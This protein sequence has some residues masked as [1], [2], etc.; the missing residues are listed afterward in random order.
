MGKRLRGKH[1]ILIFV[2]ILILITL[3]AIITSCR[4]SRHFISDQAYRQLVHQ[5]FEKRMAVAAG[6]K[7]ALFDVFNEPLSLEEKE[8]LEFLYAFMPLSDLANLDGQYL[9][10]QVRSA[11][12]ARDF[13]SWGKSIPAD[14]FR[15]FVLPYR[16]NNENPDEARQVFF[17]ELKE[18]IKNLDMYQAALEV[19]HWCH[20]KVTYQ[21]TDERTSAPLATVKTA[22][23]RCGE[24]STFTVAALRAVSLP[25]RQVYTPRWAHT[26]DNHAWVEVWVHG[27]WYYLGA[28]EPEPEL[29]RGWFSGPATRAMLVHTTVYGQYQ[30]PEEV[31]GSSELFT[32]LNLLAFYAPTAKLKVQVQ[33]TEGQPVSGANVDFCL[34]N[35]AEFFPLV[36][37]LT[38]D[39][40]E[41]SLTTGF[42]DLII[43]AEKDGRVAWSQVSG[44]QTKPAV[45]VL[46]GDQLTGQEADLDIIPPAARNIPP[47]DPAKVEENNR[48]LQQ[49]DAIRQAYEASFITEDKARQWAEEKGFP[50][51]MTW[52]Y[53]QKSRGNWPEIIR[54]LEGLKPEEKDFGLTLLGAITEKDLRDTPAEVLLHHLRFRPEKMAGLDNETYVRYVVSPRIGRELLTSWRSAV[55]QKFSQNQWEEFRANP[56]LIDSWIENNIQPDDSNYYNVPLF[57]DRL[58]ELGRADD[59]SKKVLLVALART[60]GC[61]ARINQVSGQPAFL[62]G[63]KWVEIK[64][65][66]PAATEKANLELFYQTVA[67]INKPIYFTHFTLGRFDG[68]RY[69]TLNFEGDPALAS[70]PAE[71][72][73][74]AGQYRLITGNRQADGSVLSHLIHFQ[75]QPGEKK[76]V[77]L[78]LREK[79]TPPLVVGKLMAN[80]QIIKAEDQSLTD[81]GSLVGQNNFIL[82]LIAPDQEP[83][84]HLMGELQAFSSSFSEWPGRC[85]LAV[86][87]DR[88][89]AGFKPDIYPDLPANAVVVYD[90]ENQLLSAFSQALKNDRHELPLA[91]AVRENGEIIFHSEGYQIG[92]AEQLLKTLVYLK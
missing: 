1:S 40:G 67:G 86:A 78:I 37:Y 42:G 39:K 87:K 27:R 50:P 20:E 15:H 91:A 80:P 33:D 34:Y 19:N 69:Q 16:V 51:E 57:P 73:L 83:T 26:D 82:L 58:L 60:A 92:L 6:R 62:Q 5:Q 38:D 88:L 47:L 28:C 56:R 43:W 4:Q 13:F 52:T 29:N 44:G 71:L 24:E 9:L 2:S 72:Q 12:T 36:S 10:N 35:Y 66:E 63:N 70:F 61:P 59:Y 84:K 17:Q 54:F 90:F 77:N 11:L 31:I 3:S 30:G 75:L 74:E 46:S 76:K 64:S 22:F 48:R 85:L 7:E 49:E 45:L 89:P 79:L 14:I 23:G 53:L 8:A 65:S 21:A 32:R 25:A 41:A 18:R 81:L 55:Q 68:H